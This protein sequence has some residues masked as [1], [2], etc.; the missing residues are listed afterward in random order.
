MGRKINPSNMREFVRSPGIDTR[1]WI[2]LAHVDD[3]IVDP[4][5]GIFADVTLLPESQTVTAFV[6]A[7]YAGN[8]FGF[9]APIQEDDLVLVA[10]PDGDTDAGA[11][12]ISRGWNS[13]DKPHPDFQS[14]TPVDGAPGM[15]RQKDEIVLRAKPGAKTTIVVSEGANI[16]IKIEG[17]GNCNL[18]VNSGSVNLGS[19]THDVTDGVVHGSGFDPFTGQTYTALGNTSRK[20]FARKS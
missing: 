6:G 20:V 4:E 1:Y 15:Y 8:R 7:P 5:E 2:K 19:D 14:Q 11:W 10:V 3:V 9:H 17:A 18:I 12:V 16:D 13:A